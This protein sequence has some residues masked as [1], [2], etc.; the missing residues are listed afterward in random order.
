MKTNSAFAGGSVKVGHR[1]FQKLGRVVEEG[2]IV[3]A[4]VV[5]DSAGELG[6]EGGPAVEGAGFFGGSQRRDAI[7]A[8]PDEGGGDADAGQVGWWDPLQADLPH[9][10]PVGFLHAGGA[11]AVDHVGQKQVPPLAHLASHSP[12]VMCRVAH[13]AQGGAF[14]W[15]HGVADEGEQGAGR[16]PHPAYQARGVDE[17]DAG[18]PVAAVGGEPGSDLAA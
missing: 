9:E 6:S 12:E 1:G 3:I 8:A 5:V 17:Y 7:V 13:Q 4:A 18:Q 2:R 10:P 14:A 15:S 11:G 16:G